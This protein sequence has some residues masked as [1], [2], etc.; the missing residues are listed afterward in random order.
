MKTITIKFKGD[1]EIRRQDIVVYG[2]DGLRVNT[3]EL[4]VPTIISRIKDG[5]YKLNFFETYQHSFD[6]TEEYEFEESED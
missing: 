5:T 4:D 1:L 3:V 2:E 6:G